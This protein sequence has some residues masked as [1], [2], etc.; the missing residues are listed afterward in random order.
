MSARA[1]RGPLPATP[2]PD[3]DMSIARSLVAHLQREGETTRKM[4][5]L[6]PEAR[7]D[8]K[9]HE[10][11]MTLGALASHLAETPLWVSSMLEDEM[12]FANMG[13]YKPFEAGS[14]AELV[15]ALEKN[16][17]GALDLIRERDDAFLT[18]EWT[19][20]MGEKVVMRAPKGEVIREIALH[21]TIH[22]RGQLS[23]YL[24][25]L[26]V[27]LPKVYGPTADDPSFG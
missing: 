4:L 8:W 19:A 17:E 16:L 7:L 9:P 14:A 21:H 20:R 18:R 25:M 11:S 22:H 10:K 5:A 27:P 13:D 1:H 6:V 3:T 2:A 23:V 24:R 15:S 26:G 12:D